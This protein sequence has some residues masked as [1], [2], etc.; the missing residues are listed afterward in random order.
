MVGSQSDIRVAQ[1]LLSAQLGGGLLADGVWGPRSRDAFAAAPA[2][3]QDEVRSILGR[4]G[5]SPES[6]NVH[7]QK[8]ASAPVGRDE[9]PY[10][11]VASR[12]KSSTLPPNAQLIA[13]AA[14]RRG[15]N[16]QSLANL[17][18]NV[19]VE[20][21]FRP[22]VED[23]R[24]RASVAKQTFGALRALKLG[25]IASL[26]R[27]GRAAFFEA[28]YGSHTAMGRKLGNNVKGDGAKYAGRGFIQTTGADNY[29]AFDREYPQYDAL[30]NPDVLVT[31]AKAAADA[32]AFF[33]DRNV[34]SR[35]R[36]T[37][38]RAAS[39]IVNPAGHRLPERVA[40]AKE[41]AQ[42]A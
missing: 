40:A 15:I 27:D 36:D 25:D 24:Y 3:L 37:D 4:S 10:T 32:A 28:V 34:K 12:Q 39:L 19:A 18:A 38:I 7:P 26:V 23:H 8:T 20:S 17:L 13:D 9:L 21:D 22:V 1:A 16:G 42:H 30:R 14:S 2:G 6:L 11:R 41:F 5:L 31:N 29:A 35:G 33:W